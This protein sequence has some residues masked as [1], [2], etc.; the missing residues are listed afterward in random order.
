MFG[1][2]EDNWIHFIYERSDELYEKF[3]L[4][5]EQIYKS[6]RVIWHSMYF[7]SSL[8]IKKTKGLWIVVSNL[9]YPRVF[10]KKSFINKVFKFKELSS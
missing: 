1:E 4:K 5:F 9:I 10:I 2:V 8:Q 7:R 6:K 3:E